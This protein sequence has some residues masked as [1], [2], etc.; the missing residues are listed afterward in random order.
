M[1]V[2]AFIAQPAFEALDE[3]NLD[4]LAW[5]DVTVI[6]KVGEAVEKIRAAG[7]IAG[8][9]A[10]ADELPFWRA[11][12]VQF[13]YVHSDP[14][15]RAGMTEIGRRS[16]CWQGANVR[17]WRISSRRTLGARGPLSTWGTSAFRQISSR[18]GNERLWPNRT[19]R[20]PAFGQSDAVS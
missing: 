4:R 14:F 2:E 20:R 8:I 7:K 1:L 10:T 3:G 12:D 13:F 16:A 19:L 11:R 17:K 15:L 9:L 6:D 5:R 18:V